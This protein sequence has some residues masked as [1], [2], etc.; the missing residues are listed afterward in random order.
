MVYIF[1]VLIFTLVENDMQMLQSKMVIPP[2][3]PTG[4]RNATQNQ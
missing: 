4:G 1:S 2:K 3:V